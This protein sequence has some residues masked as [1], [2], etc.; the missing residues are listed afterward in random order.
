LTLPFYKRNVLRTGGI[1]MHKKR[2]FLVA[3]SALAGVFVSTNA[4]SIPNTEYV[5]APTSIAESK[6]PIKNN[7]PFLNRDT[8]PFGFVLKSSNEKILTAGHRSHMSHR[9]HSSHYSG[10]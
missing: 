9:S 2:K 6:N 10:Y 8:N 4:S 1:I 5:E 7:N 3:F